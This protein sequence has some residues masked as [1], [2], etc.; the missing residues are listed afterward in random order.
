[1]H[2][3]KFRCA[4]VSAETLETGFV[5]RQFGFDALEFSFDQSFGCAFGKLLEAFVAVQLV[6]HLIAA[7]DFANMSHEM[8]L[9][10][11]H[12]EVFNKKSVRG[13]NRKVHRCKNKT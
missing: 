2:R 1:M 9:R 4:R 8:V 5:Q 7:A 13:S 3:E 6:L 12:S 11:K 10:V